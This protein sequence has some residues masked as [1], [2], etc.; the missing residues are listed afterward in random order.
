MARC[1]AQPAG[2]RRSVLR[3]V[4]EPHKGCNEADCRS[5]CVFE[6]REWFYKPG[7]V[8]KLSFISTARH[9]TA[10]SIYPPS[11]AEPA[12]AYGIFDLSTHKVYPGETLPFSA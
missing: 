9:R 4:T 6:N 10:L 5:N 12:L 11:L 7:P 1:K 3:Y 8:S 2:R